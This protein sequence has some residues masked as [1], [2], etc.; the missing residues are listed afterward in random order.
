MLISKHVYAN[1]NFIQP[2]LKPRKFNTA[3]NSFIVQL[4]LHFLDSII[5][6][7]GLTQPRMQAKHIRMS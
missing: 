4:V 6:L 3:T 5:T 7:Y 2:S 1:P